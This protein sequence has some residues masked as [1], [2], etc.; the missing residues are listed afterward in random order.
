MNRRTTVL[1]ALIWMG[2]C[3]AVGVSASGSHDP[4][5]ILGNSDFTV[6]NGV[7]A[8]S[9]TTEDPYIIAGWEIDVPAGTRYGIK[10]ENTTAHFIIRGVILRE[11]GDVQGAAVRLGFV[12][13]ATIE[14]TTI[15]NSINGIEMSSCTDVTLRRN[16]LYVTGQGLLVTGESAEE[17]RQDINETNLLNDYPI[18]YLYDE[19]GETV[20][21][22]RSNNL[23]VAASRNMIITE[24]EISDGD[25]IVLAFVEDSQVTNNK[26][27]RSRPVLTENGISLS[28]CTGNSI[29]GNELANNARAGI[30][31]WLCSDNDLTDNQLLANDYGVIL[32][33]SDDNRITGN[34][35]FANPTGIEVSAGS[36]GNEIVGNIITHEN[37]KFGIAIERAVANHVE[38]NA[39]VEC[40]TGVILASQANSN[41]VHANTIVGGAY[42][43]SITGSYN[44]ITQNLV[45]QNTRGILFPETYGQQ[46]TRGNTFHDNLLADNNSHVY[47]NLDSEGNSLFRNV[48][49]GKT[50]LTVSDHGKNIWTVSGEGNFWEGYDGNDEDGD[51]IGDAPVLVYPVGAEDTA[52]LIDSAFARGGLG[53]LATLEQALLTL[54]PQETEQLEISALIADEHIERFVG[55]RGF[56]EFLL[57]GFPGILFDYGVEV[58]GG[59]TGT[60]FTMSEVVF[61]LDVG[62]F[63]GGGMLLGTETMEKG[64]EERYTADG[65][66]RFALELP[67]GTFAE[68]GIGAGTR[69][70]LS[71]E[72]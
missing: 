46:T 28:N 49:L 33:A 65:Q 18:N 70:L 20:S 13:A 1:L 27:Y 68:L 55:F 57:E 32:A 35:L 40:E 19:D 42:G 2:F 39:I 62:F 6:E 54:H 60:A 8:G 41:K 53:V 4:I 29:H 11:A 5:S 14:D 44:E 45:S 58:P 17:Y 52:P 64:S 51:G 59:L 34:V 71:E 15:A 23:Y 50:T 16:V 43:L 21:G 63:D 12:S 22:L 30:Y 25:G 9:G 38:G 10:V 31:L 36:T 61:P 37:T 47:L 67:G 72:G 26:T 69:L 7:V 56:P 66:F 48:F 24:N 3:F